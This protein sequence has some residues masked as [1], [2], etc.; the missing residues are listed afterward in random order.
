MK[1]LYAMYNFLPFLLIPAGIGLFFSYE[2]AL[3]S[4]GALILYDTNN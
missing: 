1:I 3:V 4:L 2:W